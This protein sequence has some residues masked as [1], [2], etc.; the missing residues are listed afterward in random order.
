ML[1][2][3]ALR[4]GLSYALL[5][6]LVEAGFLLVVVLL[7]VAA[8]RMRRPRRWWAAAIV[9][10][11][12]VWIARPWIL[13]PAF[14]PWPSMDDGSE[15]AARLRIKLKTARQVGPFLF[16]P[17]AILQYWREGSDE[18]DWVDLPAPSAVLPGVLLVGHMSQMHAVSGWTVHL[19]QDELLNSMPC[20]MQTD[21]MLNPRDG[22]LMGCDL[23]RPI[24]IKG[25]L[26]TSVW[27]ESDHRLSAC[28]ADPEKV[29]LAT[30]TFPAGSGWQVYDETAES[31]G[32]EA[33]K[34]VT[35][36]QPAM[37][38]K[39]GARVVVDF[40]AEGLRID[41]VRTPP[42]ERVPLR[43]T[44]LGGVI[45]WEYSD[46]APGEDRYRPTSP[47][48]VRALRGQLS[49]PLRCAKSELLAGTQVEIPLQGEDVRRWPAPSDWTH[50]QEQDAVLVPG[51]SLK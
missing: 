23:V 28:G 25:W 50:L 26:C 48:V 5:H 34:Q 33:G 4:Y 10:L 46:L 21:V 18:L 2:L 20:S 31:A 7:L 6:R 17:G 3:F 51:C 42:E 1:N 13:Q 35:L 15:E 14:G 24:R 47:G 29:K 32:I 40:M 11:L 8:Y 49:T 44:M 36:I 16:P 30:G 9:L 38:W 45:E 43:G 19:A 39:T 27:F 37:T 22:E 12:A 41:R